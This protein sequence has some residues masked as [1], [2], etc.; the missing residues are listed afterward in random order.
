MQTS[1]VYKGKYPTNI[2]VLIRCAISAGRR[3]ETSELH[4]EDATLLEEAQIDRF[5]KLFAQELDEML[6]DNI[7][8]FSRLCWCEHCEGVLDCGSDHK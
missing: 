7:P 3:L 5:A 4:K 1:D 8:A 2:N 6:H